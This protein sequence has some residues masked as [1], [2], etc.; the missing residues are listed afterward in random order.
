VHGEKNDVDR[1]LPFPDYAHD[2]K[3]IAVRHIDIE[4]GDVRHRLLNE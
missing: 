4:H 3:A 1:R 2:F